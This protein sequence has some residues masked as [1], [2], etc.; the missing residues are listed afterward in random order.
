MALPLILV[1]VLE[2]VDAMMPG[3][4][5]LKRGAWDSTSQKKQDNY[6]LEKQFSG[7]ELERGRHA[8]AGAGRGARAWCVLR[9]MCVYMY[10]HRTYRGLH[11]QMANPC[12]LRAHD[13]LVVSPSPML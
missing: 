2:A 8:G 13:P 6:R 3:P 1:I 9:V 12:S 11:T 10:M 4:S 7:L 5:G